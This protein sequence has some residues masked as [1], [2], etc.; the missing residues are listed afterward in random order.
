M[1]NDS[2]TYKDEDG[3]KKATAAAKNDLISQINHIKSLV[4]VLV[5]RVF[6]TL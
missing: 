4:S 1:I 2:E 6:V 5:I 3:A